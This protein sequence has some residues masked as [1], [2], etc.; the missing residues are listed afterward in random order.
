MHPGPGHKVV[1]LPQSELPIDSRDEAA[2]GAELLTRVA[3]KGGFAVPH[4]VG[5]TG[6]DESAHDPHAQPVF[7]V[8]SCHGCYLEWQHVLGQRGDLREQMIDAVLRR[9]ARF[10]F[11]ASSDGHGLLWHHGVAR[12]RDPFRTGLTA[13][14]S[15]ARTRAAILDAI[16]ARRCYATSGVPIVLDFRAG[17]RPMGSEIVAERVNLSGEARGCGALA[18]IAIVSAQGDLAQGSVEG[19]SGRIEAIVGPGW[20]YLRVE[21]V[22]GEMAWSSPIFVDAPGGQA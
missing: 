18:K 17:D 16:R 1:Y 6:A 19:Q 5:W 21:Q 15:E 7:E 2:S 13:V 12:K 4:H 20:Y 22:D 14:Q 10:G 9:G 11:I 8:C 3:D